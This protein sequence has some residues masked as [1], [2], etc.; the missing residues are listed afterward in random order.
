MDYNVEQRVNT[1]VRE[2][3]SGE[4]SKLKIGKGVAEVRPQYRS[5]V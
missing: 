2:Y 1:S 4:A 3:I 5:T